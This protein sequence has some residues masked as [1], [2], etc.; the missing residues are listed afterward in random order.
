MGASVGEVNIS[1]LGSG[2][3]TMSSRAIWRGSS[4]TMQSWW[5]SGR[6]CTAASSQGLG[7]SYP[8]QQFST[9]HYIT[10]GLFLYWT[11]PDVSRTMYHVHSRLPLPSTIHLGFR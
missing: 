3:M 8:V 9:I 1:S 10:Y 11:C 2:R 7:L 4:S 5:F 6:S